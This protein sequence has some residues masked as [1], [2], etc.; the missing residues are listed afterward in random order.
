MTAIMVV[1]GT[2]AAGA[3]SSRTYDSPQDAVK[4][5]MDATKANDK[6]E[7][8]KILG[9]EAKD[10]VF[11]GDEVADNAERARFVKAYEA[12]HGLVS[13]VADEEAGKPERFFLEVGEEAWPFPV[14]IV[15]DQTGK[16]WSFDGKAVVDELLSRRIGY[17]E[18]AAVEVCR[19]YVDAQYEYYRLN[20]EKSPMQHFAQ[21]IASSKGKHDGLYWETKSGETPSP[22]GA[23]VAAAADDGYSPVQQGEDRSYYG[24]RYRVLTEQGPY[25]AQGAFSYIGNDLMFGGFALLAYPD[26]YGTTGVM[27]FMVNQDGV[28][29][30]KNLGKDTERLATKI[31]SF[32]PDN[33]WSKVG[34]P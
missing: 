16:R 18:L 26:K 15:A 7:V 11:S 28:I 2:A 22:L 12:K 9:P 31:V 34:E 32:D 24:Y 5:L 3:E 1:G 27:T 30:E 4:A 14:P 20:P 21:K 8:L 13:Y 25:A 10:L 6:A 23:L 17:N 29:Y 19:A 33:T